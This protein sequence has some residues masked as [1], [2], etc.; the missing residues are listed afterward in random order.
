MIVLQCRRTPFQMAVYSLW[1]E[2]IRGQATFESGRTGTHHGPVGAVFDRKLEVEA[3][4][5]DSDEGGPVLEY[6]RELPI[7]CR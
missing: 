5:Q 6:L 1:G 2:S 4:S 3:I 7:P